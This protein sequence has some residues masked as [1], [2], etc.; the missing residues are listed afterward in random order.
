MSEKNVLYDEVL[1]DALE[2]LKTLSPGTED[3]KRQ[4][5]AVQCLMTAK[6]EKDSQKSKIIVPIVQTSLVVLT[7]LFG[8]G[9]ILAAETNGSFIGTKA[10]QLLMKPKA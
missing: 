2:Q 8:I 1:K 4:A 9:V 5:E 7:N 10:F 6:S 3:Y